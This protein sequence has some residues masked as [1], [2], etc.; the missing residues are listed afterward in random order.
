MPTTVARQFLRKK[1]ESLLRALPFFGQCVL[2]D[3]GN[4]VVIHGGHFLR[5][6]SRYSI[7]FKIN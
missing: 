6:T 7:R 1:G 2:A 5:K 3:N 4:L